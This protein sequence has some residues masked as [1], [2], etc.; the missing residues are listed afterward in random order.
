M[1]VKGGKESENRRESVKSDVSGKNSE[2]KERE[3][4]RNGGEDEESSEERNNDRK[5]ESAEGRKSGKE[6]GS[7]ETGMLD[8]EGV[9]VEGEK[10]GKVGVSGAGM[11]EGHGSTTGGGESPLLEAE[12]DRPRS[13]APLEATRVHQEECQEDNPLYITTWVARA[14]NRQRE[15]HEERDR[16][17]L[18][19]GKEIYAQAIPISH[20]TG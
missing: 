5:G 16:I 15:Q 9:N 18:Q 17:A 13:D 14:A 19:G 3:V 1:R 11:K 8:K 6:G 20:R 4:D 7:G 12:G 10:S 2:V